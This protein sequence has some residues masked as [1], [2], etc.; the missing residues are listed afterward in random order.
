MQCN[1]MWFRELCVDWWRYSI[2]KFLLES[3][4]Q[5]FEISQPFLIDFILA[6]PQLEHN[7]FNNDSHDKLTPAAPWI[8]AKKIWWVSHGRSLGEVLDYESNAFLPSRSKLSFLQG[9][10]CPDISMPTIHQTEHFYNDQKLSQNGCY[11][12]G[13]RDKGIKYKNDLSKCLVE[14]YLGTDFAAGWNQTDPPHNE[15]NNLT[16][17]PGFVIT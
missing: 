10:T 9:H 13:L 17:R 14:C 4:K 8:S 15:S 11:L 2:N 6:L 3:R 7:R 16:S 12:L 5:E 1:V